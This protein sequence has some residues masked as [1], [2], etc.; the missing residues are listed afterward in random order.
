MDLNVRVS[1]ILAALSVLFFFRA[2]YQ[3]YLVMFSL[4]PWLIPFH[5]FLNF[6]ASFKSVWLPSHKNSDSRQP[7]SAP[8]GERRGG[9]I[10]QENKQIWGNGG[11]REEG[12]D[13]KEWRWRT[14]KQEE[15]CALQA[16][17]KEMIVWRMNGAAEALLITHWRLHYSI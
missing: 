12:R 17:N 1:Y 8:A 2:I 16:V 15:D 6:Y 5:K 10:Q 9:W 13:W 7:V 4:S 14:D 3:S 11:K